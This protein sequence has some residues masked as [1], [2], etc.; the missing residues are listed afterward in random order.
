MVFTSFVGHINTK[1]QPVGLM[2]ALRGTHVCSYSPQ[3]HRSKDQSA[4]TREA[5]SLSL[6]DML[7]QLSPKGPWFT[8]TPPSSKDPCLAR[9]IS[10]N[11]RVSG[12]PGQKERWCKLALLAPVEGSGGWWAEGS[13]S[14]QTPPVPESLSLCRVCSLQAPCI[15][16]SFVLPFVLTLQKAGPDILSLSMVWDHKNHSGGKE[17][18]V[19]VYATSQSST[20]LGHAPIM[21]YV[22]WKAVSD[23]HQAACRQG[24]YCPP[25]QGRG[26]VLQRLKQNHR[27]SCKSPL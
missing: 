9:D 2:V 3:D 16:R 14:C 10:E 12:K 8:L 11:P 17:K 25:S 21:L 20:C 1:I 23:S 7:R 19:L 18:Q 13:L 4:I 22:E 26:L 27:D 15:S 6:Q 5:C 24:Q